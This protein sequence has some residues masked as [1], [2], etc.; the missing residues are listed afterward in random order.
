MHLAV[1]DDNDKIIVEYDAEEVKKLLIKY[2]EVLKDVGKAFD[3][4]GEDLMD[5]A[6]T[7][8]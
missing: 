8:T 2:F 4:L 6:R 1:K 7:M 5:K 3:Q